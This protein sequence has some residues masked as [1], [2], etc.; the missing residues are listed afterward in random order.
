MNITQITT[1]GIDSGGFTWEN[2]IHVQCSDPTGSL[3]DFLD[4]VNDLYVTGVASVYADAMTDKAKILDISSKIVAPTTSYTLHR[5][6]TIP[7]TRAL[8][9]AVGQIATCISWLPQSGNKLGRMFAVGAA[10]G[11][12]VLD[13]IDPAYAGLVE[14]LGTA[15]MTTF[16]GSDPITAAQLV[17]FDKQTGV[18]TIVD[19]RQVKQYSTTLNK[20][21][22]A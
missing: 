10:I 15:I 3:A 14:A 11:D 17:I 6:V 20:R 2:V 18:G 21:C 12:F 13:I 22:R 4:Q 9:P 19:G 5:P 16:D 8:D 7:G 1:S